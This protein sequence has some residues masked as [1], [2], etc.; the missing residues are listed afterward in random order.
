MRI[1]GPNLICGECV[2]EGESALEG[3]RDEYP[4]IYVTDWP[5]DVV[6]AWDDVN[7]W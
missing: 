5:A 3:H 7:A 2:N 6:A 1:D 4:N